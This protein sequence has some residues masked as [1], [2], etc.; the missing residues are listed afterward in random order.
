[1]VIMISYYQIRCD[2]IFVVHLYCYNM[3]QYKIIDQIN[4]TVSLSDK[5][6][7]EKLIMNSDWLI[8]PFLSFRVHLMGSAPMTLKMMT[9]MKAC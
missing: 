4:D 7:P 2:F 5:H 6:W 9:L 3:L 8:D 1:M